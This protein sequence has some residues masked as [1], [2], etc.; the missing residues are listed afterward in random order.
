MGPYSYIPFMECNHGIMT[1]KSNASGTFNNDQVSG[2]AYIEKDWGTS[3]PK[4]WIWSQ[5]F[6]N[7]TSFSISIAKIPFMKKSFVGFLV[8]LMHNNKLYR[9]TTYNFSKILKL[10]ENGYIEFKKGKY[11]L[12]IKIDIEDSSKLKAPSFGEMINHIDESLKSK[13]NIDFL[14][15]NEIIFSKTF[16]DSAAEIENIQILLH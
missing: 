1:M 16:S 14:S 5:G 12:K 4:G 2:V 8:F 10:K 3:F 15:K 7:E 13:V 11:V 9:F 6:D